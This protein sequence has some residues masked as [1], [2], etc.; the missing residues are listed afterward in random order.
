MDVP[1]DTFPLDLEV[2]RS[3]NVAGSAV[4]RWGVSGMAR[5]S[6]Q[7]VLSLEDDLGGVRM[8]AC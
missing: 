5:S 6:I 8:E 3:G 2:R 7:S 4:S 1:L